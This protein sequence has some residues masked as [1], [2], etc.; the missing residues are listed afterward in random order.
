MPPRS[1]YKA[2]K[3]ERK[4]KKEKERI[5]A[6]QARNTTTR[7]KPVVVKSGMTGN[8][9]GRQIQDPSDIQ[10]TI[11]AGKKFQT[12]QK[13]N[14]AVTTTAKAK[15]SP[16]I[17]P[18]PFGHSPNKFTIKGGQIKSG[19]IY[20]DELTGSTLAGLDTRL[21]A[22][23]DPKSVKVMGS[24]TGAT[25]LQARPDMDQTKLYNTQQK[26][27]SNNMDVVDRLIDPSRTKVDFLTGKPTTSPRPSVLLSQ[28]RKR[29]KRNMAGGNWWSSMLRS[30]L[31]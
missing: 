18:N 25:L 9:L 13:Q 26:I 11:K 14:N 20:K 15:M 8:Q 5:R 29:N 30:L 23:S 3:E 6:N 7:S 28:S 31:G 4:K 1:V 10:A 24:R 2:Y 22:I 17:K 12:Q 27:S 19:T 16:P 21:K